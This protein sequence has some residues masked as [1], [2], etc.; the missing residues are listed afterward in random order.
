MI[1]LLATACSKYK[2]ETVKNDPLKT[3]IYTLDNGL[4]VYMSV[5][6]EEPRIQTYIAV[7]VGGKNDPDETTGLA[8]YFEHLMFKGT[9]QFGTSNFEVEKPML[10]QIE[11]LFEVYRKTTDE[12]ERAALYHQIDSVSYEASKYAIPSEY[13]KLMSAIGAMGSNAYTSMDQ[14]VYVENIPANQ[15][16]NWAKIEADRFKNVVIR[17]FHTELETIYEEKNMSLTRDSRKVYEAA[18]QALFPHHPYGTHTV[19]GTQEHLKN[20]SITNVKNYHDTYYVPNNMAICLSG[21]FD[22]DQMIATI[23]KYFGDMVPNES[24]P[25]T[26]FQPETPITS[27]V[28]KEVFGLEAENIMIAWRTDNAV[29]TDAEYALLASQILYNGQAGLIDLDLNQQQLVLGAYAFPDQQADY[30]SIL[31]NGQPKEGQTLDQVRDLLLTEVA[32]LRAG[33]FDEA[34]LKATVNN[35]KV[36]IMR[37]MDSN[38]GR[39]DMYVS[40]FI[41]DIPWADEVNAL[42]RL[43]A[44]TKDQL[45]AWAQEKLGAE[46]YAIVYKRQGV[47]PNEKKIAKPNLTPIILNRDSQSAFLTEVQNSTVTPIEPV[48]VDFTQDMEKLSTDSGLEVLYKKNQTNGIF[49]LTY[50]FETGILND[51]TINYAFSY[52][53]YLGTTAKTAAQIASELYGIACDYNLFA[54]QNRCYVTFSG[55][56]ENMEQVMD[57]FEDLLANVQGNEEILL[58]YKGDMLKARTDAKLNQGANFG[59]LQR[60]ALIGGEAIKRTTLNNEQI[61]AL[62]SEVLLSNVRNLMSKQHTILYYGPKSKDKLLASLKEHHQTAATMEPVDSEHLT[63][64]PTPEN[65]VYLANYDAKQLYYLQYTNLNKAFDV[66]LDPAMTLYNEYTSGNMSSIVFQEMRESRSLAY[67]AMTQWMTPS[68]QGDNY[69]F[70]AFIATQNDKMV[71]AI[72]AFAEIINNM[73]ES[74]SAF[75]LAKESILTNLRTSRTIK[76]QVL[77]SYV[78]NQDMGVTEDRNKAIFEQVQNMTL[79]DLKTIQ[80]EWIKGRTYTYCILGDLKNLDQEYL[81]KLGP[82]QVLSQQEIFGY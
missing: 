60:F 52:M 3:R 62:S 17:G 57:I 40:S 59:A 41:N 66:V 5:N 77:W 33:E 8:H 64:L 72:D 31:I 10:D 53:D 69:A 82:V 70:M 36:M 2:Y 71:Q 58:S 9:E 22:P 37:T 42:T 55:L 35:L 43:D 38:E 1:A 68:F 24:L 11:Q 7:K 15:I 30:G 74:E 78:D 28:V 14:T 81:R 16:D 29:S 49:S 44:I 65:K 46:N 73:P 23:D 18:S 79:A 6:K 13:D 67:S 54:G 4:K 47:D 20:P 50:L 63:F 39:A 26:N 12:A 48:F 51:P 27:P 75:N 56:D 45:V 19:L 32:K 21:D 61:E 34:L 25:K 76:E 80:Q